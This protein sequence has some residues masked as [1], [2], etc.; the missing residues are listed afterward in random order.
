MKM[1]F[2]LNLTQEQKLVMTQQMQLSVKMLQMS[3]Y[4]L[5]KYVEQELQENPVLDAQYSDNNK[6]NEKSEKDYKE[7]VKYLQEDRYDGKTYHYNND[8][9][10]VSPFSFIANKKSLKEYLASL[11]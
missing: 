4:E 7:L 1:D 5:Q 11:S 9:E 3:T 2:N 6:A 8:E 10:E